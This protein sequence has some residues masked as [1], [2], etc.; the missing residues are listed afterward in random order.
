MRSE[1]LLASASR[2]TCGV[3]DTSKSVKVKAPWT[4]CSEESRMRLPT[5][6]PYTVISVDLLEEDIHC[7]RLRNPWLLGTEAPLCQAR[8]MESEVYRFFWFSSFDG[9][10]VVRIGR[11]DEAITL[12]WTYRHFRLP[13]ADDAPPIQTLLPTDWERLQRCLSSAKFWS[14]DA[15][16][17]GHGFDGADWLIEGR[18]G[19]V[20]QSVCRW[21]P[22]GA[23]Y[24]LGCLF[25]SLSGLP[26]ARV[27]LY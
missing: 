3:F 26:L 18:S 19:D 9:N 16:G 23:I 5:D 22:E 1:I 25:F 11:S 20:Y 13:T 27:E 8:H 15:T 17:G 24:D 10:A 12:C 14:L 7:C 2:W 4:G 21:S 6:C